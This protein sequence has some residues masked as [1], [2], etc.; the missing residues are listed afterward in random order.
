MRIAVVSIICAFLVVGAGARAEE[1]YS[2]WGGSDAKYDAIA[3]HGATA[4]EPVREAE[5]A[6]ALP[7]QKLVHDDFADGN[8]TRN[9]GWTVAEGHFSVDSGLGLRSVV[10]KPPAPVK[11]SKKAKRKKLV[12]DVLGSLVG[13]KKD[14]EPTS[15]QPAKPER[16]EI[17][18]QTS[19]SNAFQ[20]VFEIISREK[21]G[22][23]SIDLFQGRSR[24]AGYRLSYMPGGQPALELQ[25]FGSSGVRSIV[26]SNQALSLEDN[27]RHRVEINHDASGGMTVMIDGKQLLNATDQSFRDA[28]SGVTIANDGGDYSIRE[29]T[30]SGIR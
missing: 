26:A 11:Q 23:F 22:R 25:R 19:I 12:T 21:H 13:N 30:V 16:A 10:A 3:E 17:F 24:G 4:P 28:F 15:S 1:R 18:I 9:P 7:P 8:F 29:I 27:F 20:M 2:E 6:P 5:P 14:P